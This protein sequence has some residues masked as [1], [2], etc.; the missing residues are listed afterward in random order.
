LIEPELDMDNPL[1]AMRTGPMDIDMDTSIMST[2]DEKLSKIGLEC[3]IAMS[4]FVQEKRGNASS[5]TLKI[6][7]G[8]IESRVKKTPKKKRSVERITQQ[9]EPL[10]QQTTP[11]GLEPPVE[12]THRL[13]LEPPEDRHQPPSKFYNNNQKQV[14]MTTKVP[15]APLTSSPQLAEQKQATY[16]TTLRP[17]STKS[18]DA[19]ND[20][21]K[22][23]KSS[24]V[25]SD[26]ASSSASEWKHKISPLP[27]PHLIFNSGSIST[28][29]SL[30]SLVMKKWHPSYWM[31]YGPHTLL[32]FRSKEH[33]DDWANNPYHGK[34]Q[35]DFLVKREIDF[36]I[37]MEESN[38]SGGHAKEV[39]GHRL[40]PMKKKSYGKNEEMFQFKL[41]RWTTLGCS[42]FA[43]FASPIESEVQVLHDQIRN[44]LSSCPNNG[45]KNIDHMLRT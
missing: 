37:D 16:D 2:D 4:N 25:G 17:E 10:L 36:M 38:E 9:E 15:P 22:S 45:L 34:K 3:S 8:M 20:D 29:T 1:S 18:F 31:H 39:L 7:V 32:I 23:T 42:V 24:V 28:R 12:E 27:D 14:T 19:A 26:A 41:E 13:A 44:I 11:K 43:A 30:R 40:L 33:L 35:R 6:H 21:K 5:N